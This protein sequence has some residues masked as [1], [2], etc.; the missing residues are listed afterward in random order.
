[1]DSGAT[2]EEEVNLSRNSP[3]MEFFPHHSS[4]TEEC[5]NVMTRTDL[6]LHEN[7]FSLTL[8]MTS[9][10]HRVFYLWQLKIKWYVVNFEECFPLC[11]VLPLETGFHFTVIGNARFNYFLV[12]KY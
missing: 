12:F 11:T 2:E 1:M 8:N 7:Y 9:V 10:F 3:F 4:A 5:D 6:Y